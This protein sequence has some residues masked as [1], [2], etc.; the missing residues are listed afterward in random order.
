[1]NDTERQ[2]LVPHFWLKVE[3]QLQL[4]LAY[5]NIERE[6]AE[7]IIA[8]LIRRF[9]H[10]R[11][12]LPL[13]QDSP[14]HMRFAMLLADAIAAEQQ[15]FA[16]KRGRV[17]GELISDWQP[18]GVPKVDHPFLTAFREAVRELENELRGSRSVN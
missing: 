4:S 18:P 5:L 15:L 13:D 10:I 9:S 3:L 2:W 7:L 8:D 12:E 6:D 11:P 17:P 14:V 16:A 1:M